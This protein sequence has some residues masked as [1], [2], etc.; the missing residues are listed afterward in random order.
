MKLWASTRFSDSC[1]SSRGNDSERERGAWRGG[2]A[3]GREYRVRSWC[4]FIFPGFRFTYCK[5]QGEA[6]TADC[7]WPLS[8]RHDDAAA[9]SICAVVVSASAAAAEAAGAAAAARSCSRLLCLFLAAVNAESF[10]EGLA[11]LTSKVEPWCLCPFECCCNFCRCV[12]VLVIVVFFF[13]IVL[14]TAAS[15]ASREERRGRWV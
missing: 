14:I 3:G 2:R 10:I 15:A 1:L 11:A 13:I 6:A 9:P 8:G 7:R 4:Q 12:V 5:E